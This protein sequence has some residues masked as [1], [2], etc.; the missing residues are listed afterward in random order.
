VTVSS[1]SLFC[2]TTELATYIFKSFE[3]K[4]ATYNKIMI[5]WDVT[6]YN[7]VD[8]CQYTPREKCQISH[9]KVPG[10][11]LA[12]SNTD[13]SSYFYISSSLTKVIKH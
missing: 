9:A 3:V 2:N 1:Y 8:K 6:A 10:S 12:R 7:L 4:N 13:F 5:L 11:R